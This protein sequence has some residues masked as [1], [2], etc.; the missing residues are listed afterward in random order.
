[1]SI[2]RGCGWL[3]LLSLVWMQFGCRRGPIETAR[4]PVTNEYHGIKVV[5]E[6]QWLEKG[7][8]PAVRKWS[9]AQNK[10]TRGV[11]DK[12][13]IRPEIEARLR[14]LYEKS[15][16]DYY[17]LYSRSGHFFALKSAPSKRPC[18]V[19]LNSLN[20]LKSERVILD[21]NEMD[22]TGGS[23]I[24]WYV[25]SRD[26]RLV[27]VS[28]SQNGRERGTVGFYEVDS[29]KKLPDEVVT[30]GKA[31]WNSD[32][33][34]IFYT[35][36]SNGSA[37]SDK[38]KEDGSVSSQHVRFH[39][40]GAASDSYEI[41]REFP[42]VTIV[43]LKASED[44]RYLVASVENGKGGDV[45][46]YLRRP[47]G[48]WTQIARFEDKVK[49]IEFGRDPLYIELPK[50][51][52]L[53]LLSRKNAPRGKILRMP[54]DE[55]DLA[56][57]KEI[58]GQ[59]RLPI[60]N[61][62]PA[63]SGIYFEE[64][65]R[66]PSVLRYFDFLDGR[67]DRKLPVK[68]LYGVEQMICTH[69]DE[70][71]FRTVS[72]TEPYSWQTYNV[73]LERDAMRQTALHGTAPADFADIEV[74]RE[75]VK[76]KDGTK[77]PLNIFRRKGTRLHGDAPTILTGYGGFGIS[78]TP[79]FD[80]TRRVWLDQGGIIAIANLRGGGEGGE[81]WHVSG[82][83]TNKQHVFDDFV[84]C[85][86]FLIRSNYS[87]REKLA[88]EGGSNGGLLMGAALTQHPELFKAVVSHAGIYDMLRAELDAS[89]VF[90]TNEFGTVKDAAQFD[91]LY[92][93]SPYH[94][95]S[96]NI[97][98]PSILMLTGDRDGQVNPAH[99]RKMAARL[100][101]V[102]DSQ[103]RVLLRT[104]ANSGRGIGTRLGGQIAEFSDVFAFLFD[105]LGIDYSLV[106]R[107]PWSGG[108]TPNTAIV[109]AKI[110]RTAPARLLVS[111]SPDLKSPFRTSKVVALTN[112]NDVVEFPLSGLKPNTQYYYALEV[113]GHVEKAKLGEFRT[114]PEGRSSFSFAFAS[115][116]RTG[117]GSEVFDTIRENHPL[118]YMNMGDFHYLNISTNDRGKFR[119]AYDLVLSSPSQSDL[120]RNV[121]FV[122]IWDDHDF[123]GNN[124]NRRAS[125]H[126]AARLTYEEYVPHYPLAS[127]AGDVPIYQSFTVG[128]AKFILT[129]LR[130][131]RDSVAKRDTAEKSMMGV[132][133]KKWFKQELLSAKGKYPLIFWV[134]SVPWLGDARTNYYRNV[135]TNR[136]GFIHH[137]NLQA[138]ASSSRTNRNRPP[139]DEDHWSVFSHER[140]EIADFLKKNGITGVCILHGDAHMLAADDGS[141]SD[142]ATGG[143][144]RIPVMCAAPL[145]Q[146]PSIKGGLYSQGIYKV[147]KGEGA[148]GLI[149]VSDRGSEMEV[150]Y[151]GRNNRNEE[152][153]SLQ[154]TVP[155]TNG[156]AH[157]T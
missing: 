22:R 64:L 121:P 125:S 97:A 156:L 5:D 138:A 70:L 112:H 132:K 137:T 17:D 154:F 120:Y 115:C 65:D 60:V 129:D 110:V 39:K 74:E 104:S 80:F 8:D 53:Y 45:A 102:S 87:C 19:R 142:F 54:L 95:V 11:L 58:V 151:S 25:P 139:A 9:E 69:G 32:G 71:L 100:Q 153:V 24:D 75:F 66:G 107:G 111:T 43:A 55:L 26:G 92:G 56:K 117:S 148:F 89:A 86:R 2:A 18:L 108:V 4:H 124:S 46:H 136:Y 131:E 155:V 84:A 93:Y 20:D 29:G 62:K 101:A 76:S 30:D 81:E 130:S 140:R 141:H 123:G 48:R 150:K 7:D 157:D 78:L 145:D 134:S 127:G 42:R 28:L 103:S 34:G 16:A 31:V 72:F 50:D 68:G 51:D 106:E 96:N 126:E 116:A 27:E 118:F 49:Q 52:A 109:K 133:Q 83:L 79:Q 85:A 113:N 146:D 44:G 149:T 40:L 1:M 38:V 47:D 135:S 36:D 13:S 144:A 128:R 105:Q 37:S 3:L 82:A 152:K 59:G 90:N 12:I 119:A 147:H 73:N 114:F 57:A 10:N 63:A 143:G 98:Y 67:R 6:Y 35:S 23:T 122:Y 14:Q 99:S 88:I 41:G 21:P 91:A 15:S 94:H 61:F 77:V 33:T